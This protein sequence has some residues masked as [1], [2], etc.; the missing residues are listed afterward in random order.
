MNDVKLDLLMVSVDPDAT[1]KPDWEK[2]L[3]V[4]SEFVIV[5]VLEVD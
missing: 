2:I 3:S 5:T 1:R 4:N